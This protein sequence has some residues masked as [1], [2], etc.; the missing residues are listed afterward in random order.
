VR[1]FY[2]NILTFDTVLHLN[3]KLRDENLCYTFK[4]RAIQISPT[5]FREIALIFPFPSSWTEKWGAV[6][7]QKM[8]GSRYIN[9]YEGAKC[10]GCGQGG[11]E[12][13]SKNRTY[14]RENEWRRGQ[15]FFTVLRGMSKRLGSEVECVQSL[16]MAVARKEIAPIVCTRFCRRSCILAA[17]VAAATPYI[18]YQRIVGSHTF[19]LWQPI[20][21]RRFLLQAITERE[22][23]ILVRDCKTTESKKPLSDS[24]VAGINFISRHAVSTHA[25]TGN[26]SFCT[27]LERREREREK[28][29][30]RELLQTI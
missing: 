28:E 2:D 12:K 18:L 21:L 23:A 29:K 20:N 16:I 10:F 9:E 5:P 1:Y 13:G 7:K 3:A 15:P 11:T 8:D 19:S 24:N 22:L 25:T 4:Q 26:E 14:D 30:E 6:R 17:I 27:C